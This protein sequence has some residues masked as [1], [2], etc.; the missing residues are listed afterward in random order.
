MLIALIIVAAVAIASVTGAVLLMNNGGSDRDDDSDTDDQNDKGSGLDNLANGDYMELRTTSESSIAWMNTT[1]RWEISNL[2]STGYDVTIRVTSDI[3]NYT[4]TVRASLDDGLG[5]GAV[6]DNYSKGTLIGTETLSTPIGNKQVEH[7]RL[8]ETE[9]SMTTV[10]DYYVG[11]DTKM[12]YKW[13]VTITDPSNPD[14]DSVSTT[15]LTETN[16]NAIK[17]GDRA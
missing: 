14:V 16:I 4:T 9:G 10:T 5:T 15:L 1:M 11:K 6:D 13:V 3:F 12:V 2:D 7:W 17:N 8:T